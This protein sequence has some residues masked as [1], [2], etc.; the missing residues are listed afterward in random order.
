MKSSILR[1]TNSAATKKRKEKPQI[2][3]ITQKIGNQLVVEVI[4]TFG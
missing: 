2:T 3:Q 4:H 1:K